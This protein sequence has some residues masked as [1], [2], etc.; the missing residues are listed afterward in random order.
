M[1]KV[2]LIGNAGRDPEL[3]TIG[4][5]NV[6][7]FSLATTRKFKD[8]DGNK[9]TDW[10]NIQAW[11]KTAELI[12]QY[13]RKGDRLAIEGEIQYR[14]YEKDGQKRTAVNINCTDVEFL[15]SK[16]DEDAPTTTKPSPPRQDDDPT[17][18]LPF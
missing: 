10:H 7:N 3:R 16:R 14:E 8:K 17:N 18:D 1:N 15:G 6:V 4:E 12:Q 13:V 2:T 5:N 11:G 9:I